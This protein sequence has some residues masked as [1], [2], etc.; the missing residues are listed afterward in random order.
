MILWVSGSKLEA[1]VWST[2]LDAQGNMQRSEPSGVVSGMQ[3]M[4]EQDAGV[5]LKVGRWN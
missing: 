2:I 3:W 1:F 4:R 5:R